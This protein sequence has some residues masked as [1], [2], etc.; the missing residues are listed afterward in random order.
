MDETIRTIIIGR[1]GIFFFFFKS[2]FAYGLDHGEA[3]SP[4]KGG[5]YR[6]GLGARKLTTSTKTKEIQRESAVAGL[7]QRHCGEETEY[8]INA[9][10]SLLP[11]INPDI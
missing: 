10:P 2:V 4:L 9:L 5:P 1:L 11:F 3:M 8:M 6:L 7:L